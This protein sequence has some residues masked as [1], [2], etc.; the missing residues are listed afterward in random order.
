MVPV[1]L[2]SVDPMCIPRPN[3]QQSHHAQTLN[4][5]PFSASLETPDKT[6]D[7]TPTPLAPVAPYSL[8]LVRGLK[9][10]NVAGA[11]RF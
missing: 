5:E 2:P 7:S 9:M 4:P 11:T 3:L 8:N 1:Q 6:P 10:F